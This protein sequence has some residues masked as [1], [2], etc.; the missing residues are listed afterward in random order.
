MYIHTLNYVTAMKPIQHCISLS[1]SKRNAFIILHYFTATSTNP[2]FMTYEECEDASRFVL[3]TEAAVDKFSSLQECM[4][5]FGHSIDVMLHYLS[6]KF[7]KRYRTG[8]RNQDESRRKSRSEQVEIKLR[9]GGK[10][11]VVGCLQNTVFR[12]TGEVQRIL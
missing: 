6:L 3:P 8:S 1:I 11:L 7:A 10:W 2:T 9:T 12:V 4:H 5:H